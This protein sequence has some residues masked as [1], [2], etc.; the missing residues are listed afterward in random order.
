[1]SEEIT[2]LEQLDPD[3]IEGEESL[4]EGNITDGTDSKE[5]EPEYSPSFKYSVLDEER[6]FDPIFHGVVKDKDTEEKIRDLYTRAEGLHSVKQD[7]DELKALNDQLIGAWRKAEELRDAEYLDEYIER[8]KIPENKLMEW[9]YSRIQ[10]DMPPDPEIKPGELDPSME[11]Q[12]R[13]IERQRLAVDRQREQMN[14]EYYDNLRRQKESEINAVLRDPRYADFIKE[15]PRFKDLMVI[16]GTTAEKLEKREISAEEA[17]QRAIKA[18]YKNRTDIF[19]QQSALPQTQEI[20]PVV[21]RPKTLPHIEASQNSSPVKQKF[22]SL[23]ALRTY[24]NSYGMK[25]SGR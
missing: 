12:R 7:R 19:N 5:G 23:D 1:M 2:K 11:Y 24:A 4:V 3:I 14:A 8:M 18:F 21:N 10:K 22:N 16:E 17:A 15:V 25:N 9:A 20:P 13:E 6:E